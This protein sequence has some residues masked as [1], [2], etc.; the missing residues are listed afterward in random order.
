[1]N[2][3]GKHNAS[4]LSCRHHREAISIARGNREEWKERERLRETSMQN[5]E[6]I[7]GEADKELE[8]GE[9]TEGHVEKERS[10][11]L[12]SEQNMEGIEENTL[13]VVAGSPESSL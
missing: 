5:D 6:A 3:G 8:E 4:S 7:S 11:P 10:M 12:E 9:Q 2:C 13:N 1:M